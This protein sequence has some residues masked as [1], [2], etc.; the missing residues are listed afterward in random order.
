MGRQKTYTICVGISLFVNAVLD[1]A[2]I[3]FYTYLGAAIASLASEV[4]LFLAGAFAL[5]RLGSGHAG[6]RL[7]WRPLVAGVLGVVVPCRFVMWMPL[8]I[9]VGGVLTG[10]GAYVV[11]LFVLQAFT[12]EELSAAMEAVRFRAAA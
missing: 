1:L 6:F 3:P 11:L 10:L 12:R 8:P 5:S 9:V 7:L 4:A 2:L